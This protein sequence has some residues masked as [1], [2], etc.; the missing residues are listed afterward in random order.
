MEDQYSLDISGHTELLNTETNEQSMRNYGQQAHGQ[1]QQDIVQQ[2]G[3]RF[4]QQRIMQMQ[5]MQQQ[6][7]IQQQNTLM[8]QQQ[9]V[10]EQPIV[11][12]HVGLT[13]TAKNLHLNG[14]EEIEK[15]VEDGEIQGEAEEEGELTTTKYYGAE[16]FLKEEM[17]QVVMTK[18]S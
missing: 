17:K 10:V 5:L 2:Q 3:E 6:K 16:Q 14:E 9:Q 11:A 13:T 18:V 7:M 1:W 15:Q 4:M 12:N 8:Q